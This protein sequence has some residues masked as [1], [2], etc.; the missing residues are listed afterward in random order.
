MRYLHMEIVGKRQCLRGV[1][2]AQGHSSF[3]DFYGDFDKWSLAFISAILIPVS[4]KSACSLI[5]PL[6]RESVAFPPAS[7]P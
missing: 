5:V 7:P 4:S 6:P 1:H 3:L 2:D